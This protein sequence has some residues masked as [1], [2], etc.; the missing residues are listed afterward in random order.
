MQSDF[1]KGA[2]ESGDDLMRI[3]GCIMLVLLSKCAFTQEV[4][5]GTLA[6][7]PVELQV[8]KA[9]DLA[10]VPWPAGP[11][12]IERVSTVV[13]TDSNIYMML[14]ANGI[15]P[16]SE[17]FAVV[18]DLNPQITDLNALVPET[19]IQLP[20]VIP[21][22]ALTEIRKARYLVEMTVDPELRRQLNT[23]IESL[24]QFGTAVGQLT[25]DPNVQ[26]RIKN[27]LGWYQ[28][29]E[30][31]FKR[32]TD[33]PLRQSTLVELQSEASVLN[34]IFQD[35]VRQ[36]RQMSEAEQ[37]QVASIYEDIQLEMVQYGQVLAGVAP[38]SQTAYSVTVI[39]KGIDPRVLERVRVYYTYNGLFRTL[40]ADP[41]VTS[42]G[43]TRLG[44]G[45]SE[46][47]LMKSYQIWAS[48]DGDSN[49]PITTPFPLRIDSG[50][51]T[52][53]TVDLSA[54]EGKR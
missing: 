26:L 29:I 15:A 10:A 1:L 53:L 20:S 17:A 39:I 6:G 30:K 33:P 37:K 31:R 35:A 49:H 23:Q 7:R 25:T 12:D 43:F 3:A 45:I 52:S 22:Q 46:N 13:K 14:Q 42:F 16:D 41:P 51:P 28:Q 34:A 9:D 47:L 48:K 2:R 36:H 54:A 21:A 44:S 40:P 4:R 18:Y 38:K 8:V 19:P 27:L 32:K 11:I 50:S 24:Q 5:T